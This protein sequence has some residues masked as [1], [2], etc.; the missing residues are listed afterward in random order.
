M[1]SFEVEEGRFI[2][3]SDV[4]S[5][6]S[7]VVIGPDLKDEFF[8]SKTVIGE[9]IRIKDHTY[10]IIGM[11]KP[12]GAVF[13]SNQDKNAYI[14]LTTMVNRISGKDPTSVSYTHLT[15]PTICSV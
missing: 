14:P 10:E 5:A 2:S 8:K 3:E 13:G 1:R 9:K 11:L 12:K 6:R 4:N 7:F 15:L